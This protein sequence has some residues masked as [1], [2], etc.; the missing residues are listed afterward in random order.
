M[1]GLFPIAGNT[2]RELA[3]S[4]LFYNLLVFS[5]LLIACRGTSSDP[6]DGPAAPDGLPGTADASIDAG[7]D[8][9]SDDFESAHNA[10]TN[11][12]A[13]SVLEMTPAQHLWQAN[14]RVNQTDASLA[15]PAMSVSLTRPLRISFRHRHWFDTAIDSNGALLALDGKWQALFHMGTPAGSPDENK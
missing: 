9:A 6:V 14:E 13:W 4:K 5:A 10:W 2:L 12:G 15:S 11:A 8:S 7:S 1:A 3:R